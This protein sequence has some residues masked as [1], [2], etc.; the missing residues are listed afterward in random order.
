MSCFRIMCNLSS[1]NDILLGGKLISSVVCLDFSQMNSCVHKCITRANA[2]KL[3]KKFQFVWRS[4][5]E[6]I[7]DYIFTLLSFAG[8]TKD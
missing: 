5:G 8:P 2:E 1:R 7:G 3:Q 6:Y 4:N